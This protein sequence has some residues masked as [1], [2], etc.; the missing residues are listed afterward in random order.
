MAYVDSL[1]RRWF[2][3]F[4]GLCSPLV[5]M[6]YKGKYV[7]QHKMQTRKPPTKQT[8]NLLEIDETIKKTSFVYV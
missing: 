4:F 1:H 8:P 3:S 5:H 7:S 2:E 6:D